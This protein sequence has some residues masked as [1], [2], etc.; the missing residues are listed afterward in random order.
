MA[1]TIPKSVK[2]SGTRR[3]LFVL[4][5]VA[6]K[7]A[8]TKTEALA[9]EN[10]SCYLTRQGGFEQGG[11]QQTI[12]DDRYCSSQSFEVPGTKQKTLQVQYV[13]NLNE[14]TEDEARLALAEGAKGTIIR[15]FQKDEDDDTFDVGDWYDAV[16]V[17]CGEPVAVEGE[18]NA[19]DKI[20]QK[21]FV[22]SIWQ[23]F[24]KLVAATP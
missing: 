9:A 17:E 18:D 13:F 19:V 12:A 5:G 1:Q 10:L 22:Q 7:A 14:P 2:S 23:S 15:F 16:D 4:G 3:V 6:N 24:S 21:L 11:E 8:I 20:R